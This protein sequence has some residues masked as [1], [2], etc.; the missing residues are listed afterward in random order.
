MFQVR[1]VEDGDGWVPELVETVDAETV[2][3]P[4]AG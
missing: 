1:L 4:V 3:P 2:A